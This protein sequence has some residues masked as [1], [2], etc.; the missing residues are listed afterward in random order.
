M[1]TCFP[2]KTVLTS[3]TADPLSNSISS[4]RRSTSQLSQRGTPQAPSGYVPAD[5]SCPSTRPTI[6]N[7][8]SLSDEELAWLPKRRNATIPY[9]RTFLKRMS[10]PDFDSDAYL[11]NVETNT[12]ALPNI[13][14]AISGGGYR[15]MLSGAGALAAWDDRSDGSQKEGNLGGLLQSATYVS[16]L[17]GGGWLV[18][19]LFMNN[20]TSVQASVNY[21]GIW[22]LQNSIFEGPEQYSLLGYYDDVFGAVSDKKDAGYERSL[23]DYW[24]RMLSYQ[25]INATDGGPA[26]TWSSIADDEGF[27]AG[28]TP[29]PFIV[30]DGR[31]PN[32][33]IIALNST[34]FEFT[35]WEMG[36]F[37][38][39]LGGF[40]PLKYVGSEFENGTVPSDKSCVRGFDNAGFVMGTSSS[41]FNQIIMY[42]NQDDSI[43][44]SDDIP[45]FAIDAIS[46]ILESIGDDNNDIAD[47]TPNPF[48]GWNDNDNYIADDDRLTLVDGGEDLQNVPYNP[49]IRIEREVDVVFSFDS[50]ADTDSLWPDGA[51]AIATYE[52]SLE[53]ISEG[54]SF[55]VVP[56]KNTFRNLG[57]NTRPTFFGCNATNTTEPSPLIVYIPNY[58]YVYASNISTFQMTVNGSELSAIIE[59]GYSVATQLNGTRDSD[60]PACVACAVLSRSFDRTNTTVPA[61]CQE[62]FSNYCWNGTLDESEPDPYYPEF[63]GS[64]LSI[65]SFAHRLLSSTI[66]AAA[67]AAVVGFSLVI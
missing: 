31:N 54:S 7:G 43:Y 59:N 39:T 29:M 58:P 42:L 52:R 66:S 60:W 23:T 37:D 67:V 49:H 14:I 53:D 24:G 6:R 22:Q 8:S 3:A 21:P 41:L 15:A 47:W 4:S 48:K 64:R 16:G 19:S 50:S 61:K 18:G 35:P 40:A 46:T 1:C 25:L 5:V 32:E 38:P 28:N 17:S 62:C 44:V 36:S 63:V 12:T 27:K 10:I 57:L 45:D 33:T 2:V 34:V 65:E 26:F 11:E 9:I 51:S 30:A 13:G 56:G 20:W 55:P